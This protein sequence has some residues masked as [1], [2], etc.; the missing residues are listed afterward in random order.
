MCYLQYNFSFPNEYWYRNG[1]RQ[2]AREGRGVESYRE[3]EGR[4]DSAD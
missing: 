1:P 3:G 4:R 2:G